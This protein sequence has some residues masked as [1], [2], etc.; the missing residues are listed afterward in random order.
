MIGCQLVSLVPVIHSRFW[1]R[2]RRHA[3]P[4]RTLVIL[5]LAVQNTLYGVAKIN[6]PIMAIARTSLWLCV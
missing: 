6:R 4:G 2:G 1:W 5:M 3:S